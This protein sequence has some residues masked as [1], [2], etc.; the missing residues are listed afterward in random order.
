MVRLRLMTCMTAASVALA[1]AAGVVSMSAA[2]ARAEVIEMIVATVNDDIITKS[3]LLEAEQQTVSDLYS[4]RTGDDLAKELARAK[5]ELLKD[6]ITRKLLVQQ[7]ERLYDIAKMQDSFLR[8]F[9]ESQKISSTTELERL[10][11]QEGMTLD[12]FK[13]KLVEVN[14]PN[15]VIQYEVR[16]KVSVSDAEIEA[17]YKANSARLASPELLSAREIVV[18]AEGRSKAEALD[19]AKALVVRARAGEDFEALAKSSSDVEE[20]LRGIPIGPFKRGELAPDLEKAAFALKAG[21]VTDPIDVGGVIH[22][23]KV[24]KHDEAAMPPYES[25]KEK[26]SE[27]IEHQKFDTRL[28]EYL[29]ELW[30]RS[31]V[32]VPDAFVDRIP[33]EYRKYLK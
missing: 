5:T 26:I 20:R 16:D 27:A 24:E 4:K 17:Y 7:A 2:P 31:E 10:L 1:A 23:M 11:R 13:K 30:Q 8:Q 3:E 28:D 12:E 33:L 6:M 22:I 21:E 25:V 19:R 15:S 18:K 14:S 9:K 29:V 32:R